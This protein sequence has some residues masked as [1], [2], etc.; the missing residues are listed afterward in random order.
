MIKPVRRDIKR[1][2]DTGLWIQ[3][4]FS[5]HM[6]QLHAKINRIQIDNQQFDCIFPVVLSP[7]SPPKSM[8][9]EASK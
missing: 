3:M 8:H 1:A 5:K 6:T 9:V 2:Y 4:S 7:V